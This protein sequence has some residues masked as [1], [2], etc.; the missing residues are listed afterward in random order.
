MDECAAKGSEETLAMAAALKPSARKS[1]RSGLAGPRSFVLL[2]SDSM[3][4]RCTQARTRVVG[5]EMG[6]AHGQ[7]PSSLATT[8]SV[9]T[10]PLAM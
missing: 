10:R 3:S 4:V 2:M 5:R 7:R 9:V 6:H 1:R 8:S